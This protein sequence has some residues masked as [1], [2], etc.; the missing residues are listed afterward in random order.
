MPRKASSSYHDEETKVQRAISSYKA[1]EYKTVAAAAR[2]HGALYDRVKNRLNGRI[3]KTQ[4]PGSNKLLTAEEE[5]GLLLWLADQD[6][7]GQT[8]TKHQLDQQCNFI[9]RARHYDPDTPPRTVGEHWALRFIEAHPP[10]KLRLER[11][12]GTASAPTAME[13]LVAKT[14]DYVRE[15]MSHYDCSHDWTHIQRVLALARRIEVEERRLHP[16]V[17]YDSNLITL[18]ALLHDVGDHKYLKPGESATSLASDFLIRNE[19]DPDFAGKVQL[20]CTNVSWTN[21]TAHM[22]AVQSMVKMFPELGIVQDADRLDSIGAMG[23]ARLFAYTGA[24]ANDRGMSPEHFHVKLLH[25]HDR[26]KTAT[27]KKLAEE[28]TERLR[29]YLSWWD[30]ENQGVPTNTTTPAQASPSAN[31]TTS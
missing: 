28:R 16:D 2:A 6:K 24:K 14:A 20:I 19:A 5:K 17:S 15:Y 9:L 3:P 8:P 30:D 22:T 13:E 29:T 18:G 25:I 10:F 31:G 26:M 1:G 27:G 12:R 11:P 23:I 21:E 4:R 7:K